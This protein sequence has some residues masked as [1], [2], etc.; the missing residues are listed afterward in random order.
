MN[1]QIKEKKK[2]NWFRTIRPIALALVLV[3]LLTYATFSWMKRDW[4]PTI[5]EQ[6]VKIVAGSSLVF[7][8][9]EDEV[10]DMALNKLAGMGDFVFKSVSNCTG[11]SDHFFALN[12]SPRGAHYDTYKHLST[13]QITDAELEDSNALNKEMLLGKQYGYVELTFRVKAAASENDYDKDIRLSTVSNISG[14]KKDGIPVEKN[15]T[16]AQA[17]RIS[18]TVPDDTDPTTDTTKTIIYSPRGSHAGITNDHIEGSG[19]AADGLNRYAFD[20]AGNATLVREYETGKPLVESAS[21]VRTLATEG[22]NDVLFTL[23]KGREEVI[24]V[25]IWLEGEDVNCTDEDALNAELDI[26]LKFEAENIIPNQAS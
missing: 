26:L 16:A 6:N 7:M 24:I 9:G 11:E 4:T 15:E 1:T 18:I 23:A 10:Q 19:Y 21:N 13:D 2:R 3:T 22:K 14:S 17:M 5:S 25:R 8:F 20:A 12:Y